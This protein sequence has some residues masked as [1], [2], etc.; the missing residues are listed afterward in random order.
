MTQRATL[1]GTSTP[2]DTG[3]IPAFDE[4]QL[5]GPMPDR[6]LLDCGAHRYKPPI[7][8]HGH[9]P[10]ERNGIPDP[11]RHFWFVAAP[12]T[13]WRLLLR[14]LPGRKRPSDPGR[15]SVP[16][17]RWF[18][19][20]AVLIRRHFSAELPIAPLTRLVVLS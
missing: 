20:G 11:R 2:V 8:A 18:V 19:D 1:D 7:R 10:L 12:A 5:R 9:A 17:S 14:E 3:T 15:C 4:D 13:T 6:L 16:R